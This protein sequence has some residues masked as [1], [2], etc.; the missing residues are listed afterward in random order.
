MGAD[1]TRLALL[2]LF[3]GRANAQLSC[4]R[5]EE[6]VTNLRWLREACEQE[7]HTTHAGCNGGKC[8]DINSSNHGAA[9][10]QV[11]RHSNRTHEC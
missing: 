6:L 10:V 1:V 9:R 8:Q 3:A 2:L 4:T 11:A 7:E 5:E